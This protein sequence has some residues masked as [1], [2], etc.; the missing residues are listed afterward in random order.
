MNWHTRYI[1]QAQWT[2]EL[3]EYL[4]EKSGS[5]NA[6]R[7]L[8]VGC[9]TGAILSTLETS[10][11]IHGLDLDRASLSEARLHA[12]QAW[13][14]RGDTIELPY[15]SDI[16][17]IT[18]CH[19]LLLWIKNPLQSLLEMKRVTKP[20]GYILALAEPDYSARVDKP[21]ELSQLG[22]WQN[23]SLKRQG[24]DIHLGA[25][26]ANLFYQA[27]IKI[28]ETGTIQGRENEALQPDEWEKE[29]AVLESDL[30][31]IVPQQ[32]IRH[33][34]ILDKKALTAGERVLFV[35]TFFAWGQV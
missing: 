26:L 15:A 16:F 33:M 19:F 27:G 4:F 9:G 7:I 1:Q 22:K 12:P 14:T 13:L 21:A 24:A 25:Q 8:E 28:I 23:E 10:A 5:K 34:K 18:F 32:E 3:R 29:W 11:A 20:N 2:R 30:T 35:P 31:G 6:R 17:D